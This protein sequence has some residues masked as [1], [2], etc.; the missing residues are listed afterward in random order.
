MVKAIIFDLDGVLVDSEPLSNESVRLTLKG[1]GVNYDGRYRKVTIGRGERDNFQFFKEKFGIKA[2][3][4]EMLEEKRRTYRRV[5]ER[6]GVKLIEGALELLGTVVKRGL[7]MA[8]ATSGAWPYLKLKKSG[9]GRIFRVV[10]TSDDVKKTKPAPDLFLEAAR[11]LKVRP[12]ECLV[13][14]DSKAGL[15]AAK[16]AGAKCVVIPG[17]YNRDEDFSEADLVVKSLREINLNML[18]SLQ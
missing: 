6:Q 2:S 16:A 8:V 4:E 11:R 7:K 13:L 12:G 9:L 17:S 18:K 5:I 10:I 15:L 14:E 3:L 1:F